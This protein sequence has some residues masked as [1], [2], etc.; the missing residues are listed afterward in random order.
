MDKIGIKTTNLNTNVIFISIKIILEYICV[1]C[2]INV[3]IDVS[4]MKNSK[5][6]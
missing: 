1:M 6:D 5:S 3:L 2:Y 4:K